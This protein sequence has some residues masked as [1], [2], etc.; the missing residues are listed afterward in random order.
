MTT[1]TVCRGVQ[2]AAIAGFLLSGCAPMTSSR[3]E[4]QSAGEN[5]GVVFGSILL[6]PHPASGTESGMAFLGGRKADELEYVLNVSPAGFNPFK[7]TYTLAAAP[8][9][10]EFFVKRMPAGLY[11]I[12]NIRPSSFL[13]SGATFPLGF[14]FEV[15]PRQ[16]SYIGRVAVLLPDRLRVG[17]RFG[18]SVQDAQQEAVEKLRKDHPQIGAGAVKA[19]AA[20]E[21]GRSIVPGSTVAL[22]ALQQDT[23]TLIMLMDGAED[24]ACGK[25]TVVD[26]VVLKRPTPEDQNGQERWTLDRCGTP[27]PYL[28]DFRGSP[29]GGTDVGVKRER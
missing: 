13:F 9:K 11:A 23:L 12:D 4:L 29:K 5:E 7:M 10:E 21:R 15:K 3:E 6:T 8:G 14:K 20:T 2:A 16:T 22:P 17:V 26:T 27:I 24:T 28:V 19:L 25:R 1:L 18:S